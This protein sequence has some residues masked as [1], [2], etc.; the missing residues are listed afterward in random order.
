MKLFNIQQG[1]EIGILKKSI[2]NA[3]LDGK[4]QNNKQEALEY[5]IKIAKELNLNPIK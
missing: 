1:P 5:I 2:K 3:I 4:I